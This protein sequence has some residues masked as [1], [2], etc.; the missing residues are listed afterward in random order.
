MKCNSIKQ[1]SGCHL[2]SLLWLLQSKIQV[3]TTRWCILYTIITTI[4]HCIKSFQ[5]APSTVLTGAKASIGHSVIVFSVEIVFTQTGWRKMDALAMSQDGTAMFIISVLLC[6]SLNQHLWLQFLL[7]LPNI[8][9]YSI[10]SRM[11]S[12]LFESPLHDN[13]EST[14]TFRKSSHF[15]SLETGKIKLF[16]N[17]PNLSLFTNSVPHYKF[18]SGILSHVEY[19]ILLLFFF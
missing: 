11:W 1:Q 13:G 18:P 7:L 16:A 15:I 19:D 2:S 17:T 10:A 8:L 5:V 4:I 6:I 14:R 9:T 3:W 12:I